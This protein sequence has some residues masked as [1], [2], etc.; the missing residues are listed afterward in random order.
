MPGDLRNPENMFPYHYE[1]L[2]EPGTNSL[3][4]REMDIDKYLQQIAMEVR[5]HKLSP[6]EM[7]NL[8]DKLTMKGMIHRNPGDDSYRELV[9]E[10]VK[11]FRSARR[12]ARRCQI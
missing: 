2:Y 6:S 5:G 11:T 9:K 8:M 12:V 10:T 4:P 3:E 7:E 1:S